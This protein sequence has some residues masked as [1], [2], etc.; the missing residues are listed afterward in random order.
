MAAEP[1]KHSIDIRRLQNYLVFPP[2]KPTQGPA[3][4]LL[5]LHGMSMS[6]ASLLRKLQPLEVPSMRL[7]LPDGPHRHEIRRPDRIRTGH[8]WYIYNGDQEQ[9][10]EE[11][12]CSEGDLLRII[13]EVDREYAVDWKR[14]VVLGFSQGGY[15]AGFLASR[16]P[17]R[18]AGAI[19]A[20]ARL[21]HEF[22]VDQISR[23]ELP[24]YLFV[25]SQ[26]D[27]HLPSNSLEDGISQLR[28]V[29]SDVQVK[30]HEDG[31]RLSESAL[32]HIAEWLREKGFDA[33]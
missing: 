21:K 2:A 31:H 26:A 10:R 29:S 5:A 18:F 33:K 1:I 15:L 32:G 16:N 12:E 28:N 3:P 27:K 30:L 11:L 22:L 8:S 20:S 9:F 4:V 13:E 25:Y 24:S 17:E 14:S 23:G 6:G 7:V 19:I